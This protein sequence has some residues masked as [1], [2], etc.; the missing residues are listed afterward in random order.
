MAFR[1][2][3]RDWVVQLTIHVRLV[4]RLRK[5]RAWPLFQHTVRANLCLLI[6]TEVNE[7]YFRYIRYS[8]LVKASYVIVCSII[9]LI[10]VYYTQPRKEIP[11]IDPSPLY[12]DGRLPPPIYFPL[13]PSTRSPILFTR[14]VIIFTTFANK[15]SLDITSWRSLLRFL[16]FHS[17]PSTKYQY[18]THDFAM[19]I[20]FYV[21]SSLLMTIILSLD[22][23]CSEVLR[24]SS[25]EP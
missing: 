23:L 7:K 5:R 17:V 15:H 8:K 19:S 16:L 13:F 20:S 6:L 9:H 10:I 22:V 25:N 4:P 21:L 12:Q 18:R 11:R 3:Q 24:K 14:M 2:L 1:L